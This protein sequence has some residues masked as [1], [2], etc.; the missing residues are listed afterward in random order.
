[1]GTGSFQFVLYVTYEGRSLLFG[2]HRAWTIFECSLLVL[3]VVMTSV[4][5]I[6]DDLEGRIIIN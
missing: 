1:M 4:L 6:P 5:F 3:N 2:C